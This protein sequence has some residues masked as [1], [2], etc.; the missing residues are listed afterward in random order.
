VCIN[1]QFFLYSFTVLLCNSF[2]ADNM[3]QTHISRIITFG[4]ELNVSQIHNSIFNYK[5]IFHYSVSMLCS[6]KHFSHY[7]SLQKY[8]NSQKWYNHGTTSF[9]AIY[10]FSGGAIVEPPHFVLF[11]SMS[12]STIRQKIQCAS[13]ITLERGWSVEVELIFCHNLNISRE[14]GLNYFL[15]YLS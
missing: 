15:F 2:S 14:N 8:P 4:Q 13:K 3:I 9:H 11:P 1:Y 5:R 10:P 6:P 7:H 12:K